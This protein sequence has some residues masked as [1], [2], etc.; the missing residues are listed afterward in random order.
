[1][2]TCDSLDGVKDNIITNPQVCKF[3]PAVLQC[4]SGDG[5]DCLT[6][7]QVTTA[8]KALSGRKKFQRP[9]D[10]SGILLRRRV[11]L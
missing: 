5:A 11:R 2:N 1:M 7:K 6:P 10:L 3:D 8:K 4:K 9:V